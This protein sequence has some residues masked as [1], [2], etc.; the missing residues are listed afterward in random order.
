LCDEQSDHRHGECGCRPRRGERFLEAWLLLLLEERPAHGYEL[1]ERLSE[2]MGAGSY[3][4]AGTV[5]RNLR[6]ME[7]DGLATSTWDM[8]GSGPA[9]RLYRLTDSGRE[10]LH[11]W[12]SDVDQQRQRLESYLERYRRILGKPAPHAASDEGTREGGE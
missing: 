1:M 2:V 8:E 4:D 3:P 11:A 10:L 6:R 7:E 9:R 12:A 5:Y